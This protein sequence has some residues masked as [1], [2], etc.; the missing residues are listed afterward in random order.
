MWNFECTS[1]EQGIKGDRT[2]W[3]IR[4]PARERFAGGIHLEINAKTKDGRFSFAVM[5][6]IGDSSNDGAMR[7]AKSAPP[8]NGKLIF[9]QKAELLR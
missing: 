3:G 1:W 2:F 7:L 9:S 4:V 8:L 6:P 5:R